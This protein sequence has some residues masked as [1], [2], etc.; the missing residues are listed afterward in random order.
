[1][2]VASDAV[3]VVVG[4]GS[5]MGAAVAARLVGSRRLIVV[6]QN[7]DAAER[8]A[9]SL[10]AGAEAA[11]CDMT[12][13]E[14][15]ASLASKVG[16]L[17]SLVVTAGLSPTMADAALIMEV[18]LAGPARLLRAFDGTVAEGTAAVLFGSTAAHIGVPM[19]PELLAVLDDPLT[20]DLP[21]RMLAAGVELTDS[22][23]AY[24]F[25]KLGVVRLAQRTAAGWWKRGARIVSLSPGIIDT[26]MGNQELAQQPTMAGVI[27][28]VGRMGSADEIAAVATFLV[29]DDAS[30]VS[31]IDVRVDGAEG[32]M[33]AY[34]D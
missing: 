26:P 7:A 34:P 6:D 5:G 21:G 19:P 25:S 8:V 28:M 18:N 13:V 23:F 14:A 33:T 1:M 10:G 3:D 27:D 24:M 31:G 17:G 4:A 29:S 11:Q 16:R 20:P 2:M 22:G 9:A 30:F 12:D 32:A 15:C